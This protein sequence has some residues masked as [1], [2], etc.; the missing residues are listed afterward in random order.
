MHSGAEG[1]AF[2]AAEFKGSRVKCVSVKSTSGMSDVT[3]QRPRDRQA[4][5]K[6]ELLG[7]TRTKSTLRQRR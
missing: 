1:I 4:A 6:L 2:C 3:L 5:E 7:G